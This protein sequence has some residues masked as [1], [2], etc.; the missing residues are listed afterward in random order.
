MHPLL[1]YIFSSLIQWGKDCRDVVRSLSMLGQ[2]HLAAETPCCHCWGAEHCA[3][4]LVS[5]ER[6]SEQNFWLPRAVVKAQISWTG[7][8]TNCK[9]HITTWQ[10][11]LAQTLGVLRRAVTL[12]GPG[13]RGSSHCYNREETSSVLLM[14]S[15]RTAEILV[16]Y[17]RWVNQSVKTL[18]WQ[19]KSCQAIYRI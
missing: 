10:Q 13:W 3:H 5:N 15:P 7:L 8:F 17:C 11:V 18:A 14:L 16:S 4:E 1:A 19:A 9:L 6:E 2:E 12:S